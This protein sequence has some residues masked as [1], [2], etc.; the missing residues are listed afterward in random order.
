[1]LNEESAALKAAMSKMAELGLLPRTITFDE[2]GELQAKVRELL[3]HIRPEM[4][5]WL[6]AQSHVQVG[7]MMLA[8]AEFWMYDGTLVRMAVNPEGGL[9]V[10]A[11]QED[12]TWK[13]AMTYRTDI[14]YDRDGLARKLAPGEADHL[15]REPQ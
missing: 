12:G 6:T 11:M 2:A 3:R 4:H 15:W 10:H 9:S 5:D 13:A 8:G 14:L 1:M 7:G